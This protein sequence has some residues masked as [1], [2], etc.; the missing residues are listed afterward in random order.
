MH[1]QH[2][3]FHV[4][5]STEQLLGRIEQFIPQSTPP[6]SDLITGSVAELVRWWEERSPGEFKPTLL[7]TASA[8]DF[9]KGVQRADQAIDSGTTL[10]VLNSSVGEQTLMA[11]AIVGLLTHKDAFAVSF[12]SP[13]TSDQQAMQ[14]MAAIRD[15]MRQHVELRGTPAELAQLD[16][17]VD[18]TT[19]LLLAASARR[20]PVITGTI[21]HL[22]AALIGNRLSIAS[23]NWWRHG[24][25]SP[26][27][28]VSHA[29]E[30]VGI[31]AGLPLGLSDSYGMGSRISESILS[32][33]LEVNRLKP[34]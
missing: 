15:L 1:N 2:Y 23:S 5:E 33:A 4:T 32:F 6:P 7:D 22:A 3:C 12:H 21:S 16:P 18:H 20:T 17:E 26:D 29:V 34:I 8:S 27:L 30:R 10:L 31:A 14:S 25:T 13:G 28:G 24:A 19:G 11:R 9:D